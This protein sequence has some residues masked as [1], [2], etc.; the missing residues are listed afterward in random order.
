M[1]NLLLLFFLVMAV[2]SSSYAQTKDYELGTSVFDR[3]RT[4]TGL[5]DYSDPES[6]NMRV[7]VWGYVRYPGRYIVPVYTTVTDLLSL[8]GGPSEAAD[9]E[10]LRVIKQDADGKERMIKFSYQDVLWEDELDVSYRNLPQLEGGDILSVPG[11]PK[12]FFRDWLSVSFSIISTLVTIAL[13]V[14]NIT[15][16]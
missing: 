8:A 10:E 2:Y 1:K 6:V 12:L 11:E 13:L 15:G 3:Y 14:L 7:N 4:V 9:L 16:N 5:F